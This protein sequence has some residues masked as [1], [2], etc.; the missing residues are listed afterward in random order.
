MERPAEA[1]NNPRLPTWVHDSWHGLAVNVSGRKFVSLHVPPYRAARQAPSRDQKRTVNYRPN[2]GNSALTEFIAKY[3]TWLACSGAC[4]YASAGKGGRP[5]V[6]AHAA[7][8]LL[9]I[10]GLGF[11]LAAVVGGMAAL[12]AAKDD[13]DLG[14]TIPLWLSPCFDS[15]P[16][17]RMITGDWRKFGG[18]RTSCFDQGGSGAWA[19][20]LI[21]SS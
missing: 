8:K 18:Q 14:A 6:E 1:R 2:C 11:G 3:W 19:R 5:I 9:R 7:G 21:S 4:G 12:I 16:S 20:H 13:S 15:R 17:A 10:L